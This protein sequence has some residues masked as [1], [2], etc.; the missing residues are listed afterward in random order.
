MYGATE[1]YLIA[2]DTTFYAMMDNKS[3]SARF[4]GQ[5]VRSMLNK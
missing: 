2:C 3:H 5:M 4:Q 1:K